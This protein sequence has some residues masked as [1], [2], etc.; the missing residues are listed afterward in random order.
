MPSLS[1]LGIPLSPRRLAVSAALAIGGVWASIALLDPSVRGAVR[2]WRTPA[3]V[4][5]MAWLTRIGEG[6]VLG[7]A[8]AVV[9]VLGYALV[10]RALVRTGLGGI[11]ALILSGLIVRVIKIGFGRPRPGLVDRGVVEWGPSLAA[12]HHSFPSGHAASAFALAAVLG[13]RWPAGRPIFYAGAVAISASRVV[14]DAH[15][16]SDVLVG[17]LVGWLVGRFI[18]AEAARR[19][20]E[21]GASPPPG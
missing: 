20:P 10:R 17:A 3:V 15:F 16:F 14:L 11:L 8:A 21:D 18:A 12:S 5:A 13:A 1:R 9:A 6:W 4:D 7:V 2:A 19:W